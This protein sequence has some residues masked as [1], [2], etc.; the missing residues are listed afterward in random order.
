[1]RWESVSDELDAADGWHGLGLAAGNNA[2][3]KTGE[4]GLRVK[5]CAHDLRR[6]EGQ[7][8]SL[9]TCTDGKKV[10]VAK[11]GGVGPGGCSEG[12]EVDGV[13]NPRLAWGLKVRE[14]KV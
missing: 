6:F 14:A 1:M 13:Q 2:D 12:L 9:C 5:Q 7:W 11:A 10:E 8:I 3:L 4:F